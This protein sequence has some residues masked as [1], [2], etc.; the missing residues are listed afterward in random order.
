[1]AIEIIKLP[2][3]RRDPRSIEFLKI[4]MLNI[5]FFKSVYDEH[6]EEILTKICKY[7]TYKVQPAFSVVFKQGNNCWKEHTVILS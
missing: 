5:N 3:A 2:T 1:M 7:I 6:G 4:A